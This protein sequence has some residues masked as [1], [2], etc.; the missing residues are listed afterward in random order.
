MYI[1]IKNH[2]KALIVYLFN[3]KNQLVL[4]PSFVTIHINLSFDILQMLIF[5]QKVQTNLD[6][7]ISDCQ[8]IEKRINN[9][10][11]GYRAI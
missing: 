2:I 1:N 9:L 8:Y 6:L 3:F 4:S 5:K 10:Y 11:S 7:Q